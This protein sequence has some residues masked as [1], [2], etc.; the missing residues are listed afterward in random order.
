MDVILF[1][2]SPVLLPHF[3]VSARRWH[4]WSHGDSESRFPGH[5]I[6]FSTVAAPLYIPLPSGAHGSHFSMPWPAPPFPGAF[7]LP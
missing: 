4:R 2:Y 6:Q 3:G 1:S 7:L 5:I